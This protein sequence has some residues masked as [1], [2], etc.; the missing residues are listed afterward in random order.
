MSNSE[1]YKKPRLTMEQRQ[2]LTGWLFLLPG[3]V[4]IIWMSFYPMVRACGATTSTCS[5]TWSS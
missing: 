3:T 5:R 4:L 2:S 1:Q